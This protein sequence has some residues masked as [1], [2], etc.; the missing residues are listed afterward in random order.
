MDVKR[1]K[2]GVDLIHFAQYKDRLW[3]VV[4]TVLKFGF[5]KMWKLSTLPEELAVSHEVFCTL[6]IFSLFVWLVN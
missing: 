5:Y 4:N 3:A 6:E 2:K 1:K